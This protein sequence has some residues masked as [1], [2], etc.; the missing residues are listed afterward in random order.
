MLE[1]TKTS[2]PGK[3]QT[4]L[5]VFV[6]DGAY[7][8]HP[9]LEEAFQKEKLDVAQENEALVESAKAEG[10]ELLR[11]RE[12]EVCKKKS[13]LE[14][15]VPVKTSTLH[16]SALNAEHDFLDVTGQDKLHALAGVLRASARCWA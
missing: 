15:L 10:D 2:G 5:L 13:A 6:S 8:R 7:I 14:G 4:V 16:K 11:R 9:W 12:E 3:K 1:R